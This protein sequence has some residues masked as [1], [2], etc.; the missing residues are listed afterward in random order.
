MSNR[1]A[2]NA[3][4]DRPNF[5]EAAPELAKLPYTMPVHAVIRYGMGFVKLA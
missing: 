1:D 2:V 4:A 3:D 5:R